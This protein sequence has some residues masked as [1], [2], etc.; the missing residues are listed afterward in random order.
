M[1]YIS[2]CLPPVQPHTSP[3]GEG[4]LASFH[5]GVEGQVKRKYDVAMGS[6][7]AGAQ[8]YHNALH[9]INAW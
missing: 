4:D 5:A 7:G 8:V 1:K 3:A 2:S 9:A 6:V